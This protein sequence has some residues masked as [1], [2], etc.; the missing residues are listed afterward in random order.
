MDDFDLRCINCGE[1]HEHGQWQSY[2]QGWQNQPRACWEVEEDFNPLNPPIHQHY[3]EY[4]YQRYEQEKPKKKSLEDLLE[5]F[6]IESEK[7]YRM[8]EASM[9]NIAISL[10]MITKH[11]SEESQSSSQSDTLISSTER[12]EELQIEEEEGDSKLIEENPSVQTSE[13]EEDKPLKEISTD[14]HK[15]ESYNSKGDQEEKLVETKEVEEVSI[16]DF[17]FGDKLNMDE[18]K[19]PSLSIYLLNSWSKE[20]NGK[21]QTRGEDVVSTA[22]KQISENF[23]SSLSLNLIFA[24]MISEYACNVLMLLSKNLHDL[25]GLSQFSIDPG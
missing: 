6:M 19:P 10:Q 14:D 2:H 13:D 5:S 20:V 18:V 11:L 22:W 7:N 8:Q 21:G 9:K 4:K 3:G 15:L 24:A 25:N 1:F 16:V 17:V 12:C 23:F